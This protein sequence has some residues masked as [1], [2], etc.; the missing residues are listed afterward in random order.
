[1][2]RWAVGLALAAT[3]LLIA[4]LVAEVALA[5]ADYPPTLTEHQ[6]LFMQYDSIRGW[7]NV[8][9][10]RGRYATSEYVVSLDYNERAYR[11]P[12]HAYPKPPGVF[13]VVVIGDSYIEGY[14]VARENRAAEVAEAALAAEAGTGRRV[15]IISLGTGGYSTDQE[16]LWLESEGLR[17]APDLV[18]VFQVDNDYWYNIRDAYPRGPKPRFQ[19]RGDSLVLENVPVPAP[20]PQPSAETD[21]AGGLG[22]VKRYVSRHSRIYRL[23]QRAVR[24]SAWLRS[25]GARLGIVTVETAT[26]TTGNVAVPAEF[27]VFADQRSPAADSAVDMS[28][29]LTARMQRASAAA[30]ASFLVVHVPGNEAIYPPGAPQSQRYRRAPPFGEPGRSSA[31]FAELCRR[32][33]VRCIDPTPQ[34]LSLAE[35]LATR[36]QLLVFPEDEHWNEAGN[37]L[38]GRILADA[39]RS[40]MGGGP[41]R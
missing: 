33:G 31:V 10:G 11:G 36:D 16:L 7:R 35:S 41:G 2:R 19:L 15:E 40:A 28:A 21:R 37:R 29:R 22:K 38:A 17:Y 26:T 13:R 5:L 20:N 1:M 14:S 34:F 9:G 30:R 24:R 23:A 4:V 25:V 6:Q 32:A 18:V 12:L 27:T 39:I 8:A 3:A